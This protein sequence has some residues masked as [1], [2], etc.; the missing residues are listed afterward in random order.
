MRTTKTHAR[1]HVPIFKLQM[2]DRRHDI[3]HDFHKSIKTNMKW[4][5]IRRRPEIKYKTNLLALFAIRR[6]RSFL[7]NFMDMRK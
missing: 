1:D 7:S 2:N 5:V 3:L 4:V 6:F